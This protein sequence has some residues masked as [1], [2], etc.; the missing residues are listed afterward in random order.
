MLCRITLDPNRL[1]LVPVLAIAGLSFGSSN[2]C[3]PEEDPD[4]D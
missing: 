2:T 1:P 3:E 4:A